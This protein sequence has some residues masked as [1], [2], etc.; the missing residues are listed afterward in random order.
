MEMKRS[1]EFGRGPHR[2]REV[3]ARR[4]RGRWSNLIHTVEH[5][6]EINHLDTEDE[7]WNFSP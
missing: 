6:F 5:F 2:L 1:A 4:I 3:F 7:T